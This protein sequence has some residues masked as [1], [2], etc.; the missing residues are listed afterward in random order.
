MNTL[1][2]GIAH[3]ALRLECADEAFLKA[4]VQ[5][6]YEAFVL[7][8]APAPDIRIRLLPKTSTPARVRLENVKV[9]Q[10]EG[11]WRFVYNT[12]VADV[13]VGADDAEVTCLQSAYAVDS[14]L[15]C[16]LALYLPQ[17]QGVLVHASAVRHSGIGYVFAGRSGAGKTTVARLLAD[18]A[19]VLSDELVAIRRLPEGWSVFGTPFWGDFA[20]AGVNLSAPVRAVYLLS[21]GRVHCVE[22]MTKR[23]ALKGLLQCALQFAEGA[24]V[25]E[26]M[27]GVVSALVRDIP[28]YRMHFLPDVGFWS[29]VAGESPANAEA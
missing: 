8:G 4:L 20:R 11:G 22:Q 3:I 27:L 19:E 16:L 17:H 2:L 15:R 18:R 12:F 29:L 25:A 10:A 28:F 23:D 9:R 24:Q 21:H 14:F 26:W 5:E 6:R 1:D 13:S 7:Q